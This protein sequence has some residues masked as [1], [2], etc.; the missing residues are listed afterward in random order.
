MGKLTEGDMFDWLFSKSNQYLMLINYDKSFEL[1]KDLL[2]AICSYPAINLKP[3]KYHFITK[4]W[5]ADS[6]LFVL[7]FYVRFFVSLFS[8]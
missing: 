1:S 7:F 5:V 4:K 2:D 6:L 8:F 3:R